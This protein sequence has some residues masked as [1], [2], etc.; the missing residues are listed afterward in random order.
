MDMVT[1]VR[2]VISWEA[3]VR[4]ERE[5]VPVSSKHIKEVKADILIIISGMLKAYRQME[6]GDSNR[7]AAEENES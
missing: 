1:R 4:A 6:G 5:G 2:S 7:K 3:N